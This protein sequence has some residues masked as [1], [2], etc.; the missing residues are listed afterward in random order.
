MPKEQESQQSP[1]AEMEEALLSCLMQSPEQTVDV[2]AGI[3]KVSDF[4]QAHCGMIYGLIVKRHQ[5]NE[6]VDLVSLCSA[7]MTLGALD[8]IG[9]MGTVTHIYNASPS[10]SFATNYAREIKAASKNRQ[11]AAIGT[12]LT[13]V[14]SE[15]GAECTGKAM[16]LV[17]KVDAILSDSEKNLLIPV[18]DVVL[19]YIDSFENGLEN[20][21]DPAVP[22]G[23]GKLDEILVGGIRREYILIGGR[24]GHGKTLLSMQFAGK[25]ASMG[26]RGL[27]IGYEMSAIQMLMRDLARETGIPLNQVM[28]RT[29][30]EG[31]HAMGALTKGLKMISG[32][33][34][35]HFIEN[36]FVSLEVIAAHARAL[37][38]VKPLDFLVVDYLQLVPQHNQGKERE[39]IALKSI[40]DSLER[41]RKDL[42][43][44][45]IAPVQLNDDGLIRNARSIL[46]SPQVFLRIE[47]DETE[48][49]D[50]QIEAGD[51]GKIKVCKNRFGTPNAYARVFRNG[52]LQRFED[53]DEA[54][55]KKI[56]KKQYPRKDS[57]R[58]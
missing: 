32:E 18:K 4:G 26:R 22:T 20:N 11:I 44:T 52:P 3:L 5:E 38:R 15:G 31:Q 36:P 56:E 42:G 7:L 57:R 58:F 27:V 13:R 24:Q 43:A 54:A 6:A 17:R 19:K 39:D 9:G 45:L 12:E 49:E 2:V 23:I 30:L 29:P 51:Y 16:E 28:G 47:M 50:G 21:I 25:L 10:P 35:L 40:S 53:S 46:D 41:L 8:D 34:D 33:W 14:A 1:T 55:P 37:N 48:G